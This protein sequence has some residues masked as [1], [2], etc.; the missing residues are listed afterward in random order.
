MACP[1]CEWEI[2]QTGRYEPSLHGRGR[3]FLKLEGRRPSGK[4][5]EQ[6]GITKSSSFR[7]TTTTG[8]ARRSLRGD[9]ELGLVSRGDHI[10]TRIFARRQS[11]IQSHDTSHLERS[12][13]ELIQQKN[14]QSNS[15]GVSTQSLCQICSLDLRLVPQS[16]LPLISLLESIPNLTV[17]QFLFPPHSILMRMAL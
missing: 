9:A 1:Q 13:G 12:A 4:V 17:M 14:V 8:R 10:T 15:I 11:L 3:S 16:F 6:R 2:F 7:E 5:E